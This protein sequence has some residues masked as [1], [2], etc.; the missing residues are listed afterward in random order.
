MIEEEKKAIENIKW[1]NEHLY[2]DKQDVDYM[3]NLIQKQDTELQQVL[4]DYQELI[5][6]NINLNDEI[7]LTRNSVVIGNLDVVEDYIPKS[8]V[9]EKIE[10]YKERK[11]KCKDIDIQ[12][13]LDIKIKTYEELLKDKGDK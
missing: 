3:L 6:E 2:C 9:K 13:R 7:Q 1:H 4:N 12:V 11:A 10:Y 8:K 5:N